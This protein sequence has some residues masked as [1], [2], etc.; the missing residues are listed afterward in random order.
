[1]ITRRDISSAPSVDGSN[2]SGV[3]VV[4]GQPSSTINE[5]GRA[6]T[7][8]IAPG[9]F[10]ALDG[11]DVKLYY[12]HDSHALLARTTSGTLSLDSRADGLHYTASL[13]DT[14][15][16]R[17]VRELMKRGDLT[18]SMSFGFY[19]TRDAWNAKRTER[20]VEQA[21]LVEISLV[22]DPAYPQTS[23]SLRHGGAAFHHAVAARLALHIN[24][25]T[26]NG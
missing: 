8:R 9:A 24:R 7:E 15:L 26:R 16:G 19:V 6:F 20:T 2:L 11:V 14:T 13:P 3:A 10:G 22:Q 23:S 12:N 17:D 5:G 25:M 4:Y 18:G 1:V 21:R